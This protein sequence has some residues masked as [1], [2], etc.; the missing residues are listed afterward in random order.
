MK[1]IITFNES[2]INVQIP[3]TACNVDKRLMDE[4]FI[5]LN[6]C[7]HVLPTLQIR[8]IFLNSGPHSRKVPFRTRFAFVRS[9][10][11]ACRIHI[12]ADIR[13]DIIKIMMRMRNSSSSET[14][15]ELVYCRARLTAF[16]RRCQINFLA[17]NTI[18]LMLIEF[19]CASK[20]VH[21]K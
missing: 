1:I 11:C 9:L 18:E 17:Q 8:R 6:A 5:L 15:H 4:L 3:H 12:R 7:L 21:V 20:I 13:K 2:G 14:S 19:K 16:S 10:A